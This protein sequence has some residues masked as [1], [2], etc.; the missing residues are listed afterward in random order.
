VKALPVFF[1]CLLIPAACN[2]HK[3]YLLPGPDGALM[4][5]FRL[6]D[7]QVPVYSIMRGKSLIIIDSRLGIQMEGDDFT[8]N[9]SLVSASKIETVSD[10]YEMH[11]GKRR[12]NDYKANR[13]TFSLKNSQ[14]HLM[15]IIFQVSNDGVAFRYFFPGKGSEKKKITGEASSFGFQPG[16]VAWMQ[17]MSPAK[18]G[19]C[20]TNP[21]YEEHYRSEIPVGTP[22]PTGAG[23]VLPALFRFDTTWIVLTETALDGNYCGA[24]LRNDSAVNGYSIGFPQPAEVMPDGALKPESELPWYT[25]WRVIALGS[26]KTI[27]ESTLETDVA[28]PARHMD[29]SFSKPG[30]AS[31]SW[32][33]LK[34]ESILYDVQK[35]FIDFASSMHWEY[36]LIDVNWDTRI[37]Y[38]RIKDLA[39]YAATK[40]VGLILWYNSSGSWNSTVYTPKSKLLTH[41]KRMAEFTRIHEMGIRGVKVDFFGGDGQ[42]VIRYYT[43]ILED[44]AACGLMVNFH[45]CTYPRSW[46]RTWPNLLSMESIKGMEFITFTQENAD[47]APQHCTIIP[48]T[49]NLFSPMD[50]TPM[51]LTTIPNI[52]R[53]TTGT[54]ELALSVLF[55][56]GI[57]HYAETPEGMASVPAAVREFLFDIPALWD[58]T[59]FV[60]GYPG[61]FVVIARRSGDSWYVAG[62]NGE[63]TEKEI[64]LLLPFVTGKEG[65]LITDDSINNSFLINKI[66]FNAGKQLPVKLKGSGGFVLK[67]D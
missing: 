4:V 46:H 14:G 31:W 1:L 7:N 67:I 45:G 33:M 63:N 44:A 59:E 52:K 25:P 13:R 60:E 54:F 55:L 6:S 36:C 27:M 56:S 29:T 65:T 26:L 21:S 30:Q 48:F 51:N 37:G 39:D 57:Q 61:K 35:K 49:R 66:A 38:E 41:D 12:V 24:R 15:D 50:F 32:I 5:T 11:H 8:K 40:K 62:I 47:L 20:E 22:A 58:D 18:S 2:V 10:S 42:S 53:K 19:W 28:L 34:D 17:P 9:L 16:T 3:K 43:E 23:W 64:N